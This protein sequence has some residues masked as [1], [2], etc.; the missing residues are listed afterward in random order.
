MAEDILEQKFNPESGYVV[1]KDYVLQ[2]GQEIDIQTTL[3]PLINHTI[4]EETIDELE[5]KLK[6]DILSD[7]IHSQL[8]QLYVAHEDRDKVRE[9]ISASREGSEIDYSQLKEELD[10]RFHYEHMPTQEILDIVIDEEVENVIRGAYITGSNNYGMTLAN[11]SILHKILNN[12]NNHFSSSDIDLM[13]L[14]SE[15]EANYIDNAFEYFYEEE[16]EVTGEL[17]DRK[18]S[19]IQPAIIQEEELLSGIRK[20]RRDFKAGKDLQYI[21]IPIV[22]GENF[23]MQRAY[24]ELMADFWAGI[25]AVDD[26]RSEKFDQEVLA[27]IAEITEDD[28]LKDRVY[29]RIRDYIL[30][31]HGNSEN[32]R[33]TALENNFELGLKE[34]AKQNW[35]DLDISSHS[36]GDISFKEALKEILRTSDENM[37]DY[38]DG[39]FNDFEIS[40]RRPGR[41]ST[42]DEFFGGIPDAELSTDIEMKEYRL[43]RMVERTLEEHPDFEIVEIE[44]QKYYETGGIRKKISQLEASDLVRRTVQDIYGRKINK[45]TKEHK[46]EK[47][48]GE[49]AGERLD[50][51]SEI[52]RT[53]KRSG[54]KTEEEQQELN[55]FL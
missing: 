17:N 15:V 39:S 10:K 50:R 22:D 19:E 18:K 23:E 28:F 25:S 53:I 7:R 46:T 30:H 42:L 24:T 31:K 49:I 33:A 41:T 26:K 54:Q 38:V 5:Y 32:S 47:S 52:E 27:G 40:D 44:D 36:E 20:G 6:E 4:V 1:H 16:D 43:E 45:L 48:F 34:M 21:T 3:D 14:M 12:S 55:H 35:K 37:L 51:I 29:D 2:L 11:D 13:V 8:N 9:T